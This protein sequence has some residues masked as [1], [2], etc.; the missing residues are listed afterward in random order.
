A[1]VGTTKAAHM[2]DNVGGGIGRLPN[3]ATRKR[4]ADFVDALPAR[5]TPAAALG[6]GRMVATS[7]PM[8]PSVVLSAA[9]LDRYVG[10]YRHVAAGTTVT[11]RRDGD[12]LLVDVQDS[13]R[14][15]MTFVASSETR[16]ISAPIFSIEFHLDGQGR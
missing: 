11:I 1:R 9:I 6:A 4:M 8:Q 7:Q 15:P 10:E 13:G 14:S 12:K 16:F 5:A 2:L 3:E